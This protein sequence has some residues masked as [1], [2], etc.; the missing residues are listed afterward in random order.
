MRNWKSAHQIL[1]QDKDAHSRHFYST[2]KWKS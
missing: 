2:Q 1:E